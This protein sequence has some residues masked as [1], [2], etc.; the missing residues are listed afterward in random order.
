MM[1]GGSRCLVLASASAARLRM[2]RA[3]GVAVETVSIKAVPDDQMILDVG[4]A[5]AQHLG[6]RLETCKTLVWNGPLGAFSL[7]AD[8]DGLFGDEVQQSGAIE[9]DLPN[10]LQREA[11]HARTE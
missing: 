4:P 7:Q 8:E 2:L 9:A 3:A 1:A 6:R 10:A 5:T 11:R